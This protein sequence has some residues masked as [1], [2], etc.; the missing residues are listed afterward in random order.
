MDHPL[1][2]RCH[3]LQYACSS[4]EV[5]GE[6]E[7]IDK[8]LVEMVGEVMV[9]MVREGVVHLSRHCLLRHPPPPPPP[10]HT[11]PSPEILIPPQTYIS[12]SIPPDTYTSLLYPVSSEPT[13]I[14]ID[15][16]LSSLPYH[17]LHCLPSMT[18]C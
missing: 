11:Y 3:P 8:V 14:V 15:I 5:E 6:G 9:E 17:P 7:L 16:T 1:D 2:L 12:P 10:P 13:S 18:S 4:F